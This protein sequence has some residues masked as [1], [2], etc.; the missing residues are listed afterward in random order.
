MKIGYSLAI[1]NE[2]AAE[3]I[4]P[5]IKDAGF[6][7]FEP[8]LT[9]KD[10]LPNL[11]AVETSA[12]RLAALAEKLGLEI[13]SMRGGPLFWPTFASPNAQDRNRAVEIAE[14][15]LLAVKILGGSALLVVP[16]RLQESKDYESALRWAIETA[17]RVAE[18][19]GKMGIR[20]G[21]ENVANGL[22][23]SPLELRQA[24][25]EIGS[26]M[27]GAYFDVGNCLYLGQG[28]PENWIRILGKR[29]VRVH[30]KDAVERK[31]IRHL[32]LGD[33]D[34]PEVM[35]ALRDVGYDD[36]VCV[37]LPTYKLAPHRMLEE[38]RKNVA[39]ILSMG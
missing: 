39:E 9:P 26:P 13:P 27:V 23:L 22:F 10:G 8:T 35:R 16:G 24:I 33:V 11:E 6:D 32:L 2:K 30:F 15:A 36:Y 19:A 20:V 31:E 1:G 37:E 5:M 12:K 14:K 34:W 38:T 25:D 4:L 29:I 28:Y 7:G 3:R 17:K 18:L 21:L